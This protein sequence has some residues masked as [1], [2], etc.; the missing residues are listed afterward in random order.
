MAG[1]GRNAIAGVP[2]DVP[3]CRP[4]RG[5]MVTL[6]MD[7]AAPLITR[8]VKHPKGVLCPRSDGRLLAGPTYERGITSLEAD[9]E[10]VRQIL[11]PAIRAVPAVAKLERVEVTCGIRALAGDGLIR[12]GQS[13]EM[14][15]LY[16]SLSQGARGISGRR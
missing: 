12:L 11:A 15:G 7:P 3:L 5:V 9:E 16:Y 1:L 14:P 13:R 10:V 8:M 2:G 4:V 6:A